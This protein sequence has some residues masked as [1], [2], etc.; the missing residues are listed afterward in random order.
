MVPTASPGA[1]SIAS[2]RAWS[3]ALVSEGAGLPAPAGLGRAAVK[4]ECRGRCCSLRLRLVG[5]SVLN[6][7]ERACACPSQ[8][9]YPKLGSGQPMVL[10]CRAVL[11]EPQ[12]CWQRPDQKMWAMVVSASSRLH[13]S[14]AS[15]DLLK[16][17][18]HWRLIAWF[19]YCAPS[20]GMLGR[21]K[22]NAKHT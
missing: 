17:N 10:H 14:L 8:A 21:E 4:D 18:F 13:A 16:E 11:R 19:S 15:K 5:P 1:D 2:E 9:A 20:S 12:K 3:W 6:R 7:P 22:D